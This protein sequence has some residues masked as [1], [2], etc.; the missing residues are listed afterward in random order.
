[1]VAWAPP[2]RLRSPAKYFCRREY[3]IS[4]GTGQGAVYYD[5]VPANSA[6]GNLVNMVPS[7]D[8]IAEF[9]VQTNSNN[10]EFGRYAGGVINISSR[11][12]SN[13]FH[14][15]GYEYFLNDVLKLRTSSQCNN[16]E[17]RIQAEPVWSERR[18]AR[19][20]EQNLCLRRMGSVSRPRGIAVHRDGAASGNV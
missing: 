2:S 5:G 15:S 7:P 19:Q 10:A 14:G 1:V 17:S 20:K 6:L 3:Q 9:R 4:G 16:T 12:G 18:R 11:S 13:Q 8:A